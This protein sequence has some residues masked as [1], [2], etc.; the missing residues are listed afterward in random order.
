[1]L[2][3]VLDVVREL[4]TA[5]GVPAVRLPHERGVHRRLGSAS[6]ARIRDI[7]PT[8]G[9]PGGPLRGSPVVSRRIGRRI[10]D[11]FE[12]ERALWDVAVQPQLW[13]AEVAA[14]ARVICLR[15]IGLLVRRHLGRWALGEE[16]NVRR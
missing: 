9:R 6:L 1:M 15:S 16:Q 13:R 14:G 11:Y 5:L 3:R 12:N 4:A 7:R 2:P 10:G 8:S